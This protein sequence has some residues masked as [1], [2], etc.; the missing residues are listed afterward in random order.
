MKQHELDETIRMMRLER[1]EKL[2]SLK[3]FQTENKANIAKLSSLIEKF[4]AEKKQLQLTQ[5]IYQQQIEKIASEY[6]DKIKEFYNANKDNV[7]RDLED[8]SD[9]KLIKEL[10]ARGFRGYL[11]HNEK[12]ADFLEN[13]NRKLNNGFGLVGGGTSEQ[14]HDNTQ[15]D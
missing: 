4:I 7:T 8:E 1:Y 11:N 6:G 3:E 10:H 2:K 5:S 12:P 15:A 13:I 9:W 14:Q